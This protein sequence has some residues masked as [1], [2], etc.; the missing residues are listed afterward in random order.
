MLG[1]KYFVKVVNKVKAFVASLLKFDP[2]VVGW[3]WWDR[4][5]H[6]NNCP[7]VKFCGLSVLFDGMC[8]CDQGAWRDKWKQVFPVISMIKG[9]FCT[10]HNYT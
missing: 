9:G 6:K 3:R 4:I 5:T 10:T 2:L 8:V 7:V 1:V